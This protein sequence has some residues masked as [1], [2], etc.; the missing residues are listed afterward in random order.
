MVERADDTK[1]YD[2]MK[3]DTDTEEFG[4]TS[5]NMSQHF[6]RSYNDYGARRFG[7][8]VFNDQVPYDITIDWPLMKPYVPFVLQ[9]AA[10][11]GLSGTLE[12]LLGEVDLTLLLGDAINTDALGDADVLALLLLLS[13]SDLGL[14]IDP[15]TVE[16]L[17][18]TVA[19]STA[20][21]A[22][23]KGAFN[24]SVESFFG[25]FNFSSGNPVRAYYY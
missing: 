12:E 24:V 21:T 14:D 7:S 5:R 9:L 13:D 10:Q 25:F 23:I 1:S 2:W 22:L 17:E 8:Y 15:S 18:A 3:C 16:G 6:L 19:N 11:N 4:K 20:A